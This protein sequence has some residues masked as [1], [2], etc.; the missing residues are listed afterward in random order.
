MAESCPI[1]TFPKAWDT[2][3]AK[4]AA[5][6]FAVCF[7]LFSISLP[8]G[9]V[10][11]DGLEFVATAA[12][13]GVP[14]PTGYPL[15]IEALSPFASS[16]TNAAMVCSFFAAC[17]AACWTLLCGR[18][19]R[20]TLDVLPSPLPLQCII[21][22][23]LAGGLSSALWG[24][25]TLVEVY[26][27]NALLMLGALAILCSKSE[28]ALCWRQLSVAGLLLSLGIANHLS[29]LAVFPLFGFRLLESFRKQH[30]G[31]RSLPFP[32]LAVSLPAV[33]LYGLLMLRAAQSPAI[34]WGNAESLD[35]LMWLL[36]GGDY[37]SS[38]FLQ[39]RPGTPFTMGTWIPHAI[40]ILINCVVQ[41][42]GQLFGFHPVAGRV[43]VGLFG[44][45]GFFQIGLV[46]WGLKVLWTQNRFQF[47]GLLLGI[48]FL[49]F[50]LLTYRIP[51]ISDYFLSLYVIMG[52]PLL[53]GLNELI[54]LIIKNFEYH[55]PEKRIRL[56]VL[57][58]LLAVVS[59]MANS[60]VGMRQNHQTARLVLERMTLALPENALLITHGDYD[61]YGMW[62][63]QHVQGKKSEV[64]VVGANFMRQPWY[65]AMLPAEG[66]DPHGRYVK[67]K[68][69]HFSQFTA[70]DQYAMI[71]NQIIIP[72]A[73]RVPI[74][75]T[76]TDPLMLQ[77]LSQ[78]F[79]LTVVETLLSQEEYDV[80]LE[81]GVI[82][83]AIPTQLYRIEPL[84]GNAPP[85]P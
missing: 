4:A 13:R 26:G 23:G 55:L 80:F 6:V 53:I 35:G 20:R 66:T 74:F 2:E 73:S 43:S 16:Y 29:I 8:R 68:P 17:A 61:I 75:T 25:A 46:V 62:Y 14:H 63:A 57:I 51:D 72:N 10:F 28:S 30:L 39:E 58:A 27:L 69:G 42:G 48:A 85:Q 81:Q 1:N 22:L 84:A 77:Y 64:L 56:V 78:E 65:G 36:T 59:F 37:K 82:A 32:L 70:D 24:Q 54:K 38:Q 15:F 11:G 52:A 60:K 67:A 3:I 44:L 49:L 33:I 19:L 71:R 40:S 47:V 34:N 9:P 12:V 31:F 83:T 79:R 21:G 7:A 50:L 41:Y 18:L 5:I 45:M 76:D